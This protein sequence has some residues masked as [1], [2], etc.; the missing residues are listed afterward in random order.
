MN[1][2][3]TAEVQ[4]LVTSYLSGKSAAEIARLVNRHSLRSA[5]AAVR[6]IAIG[7]PPAQD[8]FS[9]DREP[10]K[11]QFF[12]AAERE[13]IAM[14]YDCQSDFNT[15]SWVEYIHRAERTRNWKRP[16]VRYIC[17]VLRCTEEELKSYIFST[18]L[19]PKLIASLKCPVPE[20]Q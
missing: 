9:E 13:V 10:I 5:E 1:T 17:R 6:K 7:Y 15:P 12:T 19:K 8:H 14:W 3:K 4:L 20:W 2:M 18:Y 16:S 11:R